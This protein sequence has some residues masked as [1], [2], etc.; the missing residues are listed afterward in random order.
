MIARSTMPEVQISKVLQVRNRFMRSVHLERDFADSGALEGYSLTPQ[1]E[2]NFGRLFAGLSKTSGQR[3]WRITG[4]YGSGKSSFALAR[5]HM[6]SGKTEALP[7]QLR[8]VVQN[9]K[10]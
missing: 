9:S 8:R 5:A 2:Q 10:F 4:D 6:L 3:A 7:N 1:I